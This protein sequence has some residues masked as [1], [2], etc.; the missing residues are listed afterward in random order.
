MR[1]RSTSRSRPSRRRRR[2][3][4]FTL[5]EILIVIAVIGIIAALIV[6]NLLDSYQKAK[7]KRTMADMR[8]VGATWFNWLSDAAS[9]A[10]AGRRQISQFDWS[11]LDQ[12]LT[13]QQLSDVLVPQYAAELPRTDQWSRELEFARTEDLDQQL[14]FG[15]RSGGRDGVFTDSYPVE[16]FS[17]TDYDQDLVW[18]GGYFLRWPKGL[19]AP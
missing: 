2:A 12:G 6:P 17:A 10:A 14:P 15:V 18:V 8:F 19:D 4:G 7:Q 9:A 16:A 1:N 13:H 11:E 5:I 3:G